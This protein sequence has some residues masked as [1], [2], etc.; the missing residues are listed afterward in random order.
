MSSI[1]VSHF[2]NTVDSTIEVIIIAINIIIIYMKSIIIDS[3]LIPIEIVVGQIS[4]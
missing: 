2:F 3:N 4:P 1:G